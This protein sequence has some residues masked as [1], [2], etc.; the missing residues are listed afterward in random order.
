MIELK[1]T[2]KVI[3]NV[4]CK[5]PDTK[6]CIEDNHEAEDLTVEEV[7]YFAFEFLERIG[8][9]FFHAVILF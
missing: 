6:I 7:I 3:H 9:L 8:I 2:L 1:V 4:D 5:H